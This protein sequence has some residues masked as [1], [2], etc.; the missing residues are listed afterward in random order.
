MS[1]LLEIADVRKQYGATIAL[2]NV[3]FNVKRGAVH[4]IIGENG[5]GKSTL[6]KILSGLVQ[7]DE[8]SI[9]L[10]GRPFH[11]NTIVESRHAGVSTAFQELSL[12]TNLTVA[13]NL[14]LPNM[15][16]KGNLLISKKEN[17]EHARHV[18]QEF[19]LGH[20]SPTQ[21]VGT[22]TLAE[23]QKLEIT[24]ALSHKPK[25]LLLDEPTAALPDPE[26]LFGILERFQTADLTIL[27]I[28]HR[29]NEIRRVCQHATILRNGTTIET[30]SLEGV[31][32]REIFQ[33]MLGDAQEVSVSARGEDLLF[34]QPGIEVKNLQGGK[35]QNVSFTLKK[36]EILGIAGLEGQ[37]QS[38]LFK[39]LTG[40]EQ[41][42]GG[43]ISVNGQVAN[44]TSPLKALR[45]GISFVPEER[46][47]EGILPGHKTLANI[48]LSSL[49]KA[50]RYG[51][52]RNKLERQTAEPH[53][54]KV[55][56]N[57]KFIEMNIESLSGGNQQKA[58]V[59][60]ALMTGSKYLLLYDPAR[61]VDVGT[62][63]VFYEVIRSFCDEGGSVLWYSTELS[64]LLNVCDRCLVF[65]KGSIVSDVP[66]EQATLE[67]L[68]SA[69]TGH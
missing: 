18:L 42:S 32:N 2:N 28:S 64:E 58:I 56:M 6:I 40:V 34:D 47:T 44:I 54:K 16:K 10:D 22:L 15:R 21:E 12:L 19:D 60:R 7:C 26:W 61:G 3:S 55:Q 53:A 65:Y 39:M 1:A 25:M 59:A 29:L 36:G 48:T 52:L 27:Y 50:A 20:I 43:T 4:A 23:R 62:K 35:V 49:S 66:K 24:R 13:E 11:P 57:P 5:A 31:S 68:L 14:A 45:Y 69:A 51:L 33:M 63:Q 8:G 67:T 9:L 37:G 17:N 38:D 46:K 41:V 30:V